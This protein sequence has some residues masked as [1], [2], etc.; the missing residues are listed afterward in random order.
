MKYAD[1][2]KQAMIMLGNHNK[3]IFIGQSVAYPGNV[4]YSNMEPVAKEKKLELPVFE[5]TQMG[6]SIGLALAGYIP[7]S[8]YPRFNF[9]L[10][11]C[12]QLFNHLDKFHSITGVQPH[13][14]I[15]TMVGSVKPLHP[16]VQHCSN[17]TDAFKLMS[18]TLQVRELLE[19]EQ[20]MPAYTEAL[21]KPGAYLIVEHGDFYNEK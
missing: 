9:L 13:V 8:I 4:I 1:E 16:G 11:A 5:E 7:V 14:I 6:M 3:T 18:T 17:F 21:E 12:N 19:P 15:K 2:I 20:V 10:L